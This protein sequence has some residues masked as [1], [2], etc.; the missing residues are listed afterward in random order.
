L[1]V[2]V[3]PPS[4]ALEALRRVLPPV[5]RLTPTSKWHLTLFFLG[6]VEPAHADEVA[7]ILGDVQPPGRFSLRLA[8]GGRFGSVAWAG[9]A[10]DLARLAALRTSVH[11]A[12][13]AGGFPHDA[14]TWTPHLTVSYRGDRAT[15]HALSDFAGS[16]WDVAEF[17]LVRS[18][19]GR[20]EQ[21]RS[22]PTGG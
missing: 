19:G 3:F 2:A 1:F 18:Q 7:R 15:W 4:D 13:T 16:E 17:A 12:L 10:G 14:R 6:E 9:V 21:L 20:Y 22:W 8:G 5:A 11:D